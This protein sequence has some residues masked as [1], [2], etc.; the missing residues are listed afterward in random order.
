VRKRA[1]G[2]DY[3]AAAPPRDERGRVERRHWPPKIEPRLPGN[4]SRGSGDAVQRHG[5]RSSFS[6][7]SRPRRRSY[8]RHR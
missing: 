1:E 5:G 2:F 6:P 8:R 7:A 4:S 3:N